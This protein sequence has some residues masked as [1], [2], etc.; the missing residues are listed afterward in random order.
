MHK[1][2]FDGTNG[3]A[4]SVA[5][6]D[7]TSLSYT[8]KLYSTELNLYDYEDLIKNIFSFLDTILLNMQKA[9]NKNHKMIGMYLCDL[10]KDD[11]ND[12]KYKYSLLIKFE[13]EERFF[14]YLEFDYLDE[15]SNK[16]FNENFGSK[17]TIVSDSEDS[18]YDDLLDYY[19]SFLYMIAKND[20]Y[21]NYKKYKI[22]T[23][24]NISNEK[25]MVDSIVDSMKDL[26]SDEAFISNI[27]EN[28][29]F[30][31]CTRRRSNFIT[32]LNLCFKVNGKYITI[33][34]DKKIAIPY[35]LS[36]GIIEECDIKDVLDIIL[37]IKKCV[38]EGI[39]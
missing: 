35:L 28:K 11:D 27:Y 7:S 39:Y 13:G 30:C 3:D 10:S 17:F 21:F 24:S 19:N 4:I 12:S 6:G 29:V 18:K 34:T 32:S 36:L 14:T 25:E 37:N 8:C 5:N 2:I 38:K 15:D 33:D 26:G 20:E 1:L 31:V 16:Y 23:N 9:N 22:Y